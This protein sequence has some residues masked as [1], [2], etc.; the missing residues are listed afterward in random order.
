MFEDKI[1]EANSEAIASAKTLADFLEKTGNQKL[2]ERLRQEKV[3]IH[4][5]AVAVN[6]VE[7]KGMRQA[8]TKSI[9]RYSE[10]HSKFI[11]YDIKQEISEEFA[12]EMDYYQDKFS[13]N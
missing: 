5:I 9:S 2:A 7:D 1:D 13:K 3:D 12:R 4:E 6:N 8:M 10:A 11:K